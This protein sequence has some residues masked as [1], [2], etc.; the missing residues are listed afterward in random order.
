MR[1]IPLLVALACLVCVTGATVP[2]QAIP[3]APLAVKPLP[4]KNGLKVS[5]SATYRGDN[6]DNTIELR[7]S[8]PHINVVLQNT[9]SK[10][11]N[12]FEEWNSWGYDNLTLKITKVDGKFLDKPLI[13]SKGVMAWSA[14]FSSAETLSPG[15]VRVR[16]ARLQVPAQIF[17]PTAPLTT[18]DLN[19][20][21]PF[22]WEFP[23]PPKDDSRQVTMSAVFANDDAVS[24]TGMKKKVVWTGEIASPPT[25]YRIYWGSDTR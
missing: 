4:E 17:I 9:S 20:R 21:G 15:E 23:F 2:V 24:D 19:A 6:G 18:F 12:I 13:V 5:I 3:K 11:I 8:A 7:P 14:N 22:Y 16:E 10:P 25:D 1:A